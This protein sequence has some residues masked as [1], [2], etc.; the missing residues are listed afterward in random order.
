M[1]DLRAILL[2]PVLALADPAP[3]A[4]PPPPPGV[5]PDLVLPRGADDER[6]RIPLDDALRELASGLPV[7][8]AARERPGVA[9]GAA[10]AALRHYLAA[11][12]DLLEERFLV[13]ATHLR[14]ARQLD[15]GSTEI[16]RELAHAY[17]GLRDASRERAAYAELFR[18]D[19]GDPEAQFSMGLVALNQRDF[20]SAARLFARVRLDGTDTSF[21]PAAPLIIDHALHLTL[22]LLGYD[23]ASI[24]AG[25]RATEDPQFVSMT[26]YR[27]RVAGIM[28]RRP[29]IWREIGEAHLR[30]VERDQALDA[31]R[32]SAEL[33]DTPRLAARRAFALLGLGRGDEAQRELVAR[34]DVA[35]G[36]MGDDLVALSR[37]LFEPAGGASV[38]VRDAIA[39]LLERRPDDGMLLRV[40]YWALRSPGV[41][42]RLR[43]RVRREPR[44]VATAGLLMAIL[45]DDEAVDLAVALTEMEPDLAADY[46]S[47]LLAAAPRPLPRLAG[48]DANRPAPES[49]V[50]VEIAVRILL[51]RTGLG[52]AWRWCGYGRERWPVDAS[53]HRLEIEVAAALDEPELLFA[54]LDAARHLDDAPTWTV[55]ASALTAIEEY[56]R[57]IEAAQRAR[58]SAIDDR[59]RLA[60]GDALV[61][62]H[63]ARAN[64]MSLDET[65][66]E[67]VRT[68]VQL[69]ESLEATDPADKQR[70]L[71][72][73]AFLHG[74]SGLRPSAARFNRTVA[75]ACRLR[76]ESTLCWQLQAQEA[77][78]F[79]QYELALTRALSLVER[80]A[81]DMKSLGQVLQALEQMQ[82]V[83]DAE[84]WLLSRLERT[85]GLPEPLDRLVRILVALD[86]GGEALTLL[87]Q[88]REANPDD[89]A[90]TRLLEMVLQMSGE[91]EAAL[92]LGQ[93]RL[94]GRPAGTRRALQRALLLMRAGR[95]D[96]ATER[97]EWLI[98][99]DRHVP[100]RHLLGAIA[101]CAQLPPDNGRREELTAE[102]VERAVEQYADLPM[103]VYALGLQALAESGTEAR[104]RRLAELG[105]RHS[106][107]ADEGSIERLLAWRELAQGLVNGGHA[108]P[109][110]VALRTRLAE[111][112][113]IGGEAP[114]DPEA[115][116]LVVSM[117]VAVDSLSPDGAESSL[118]M[119]VDLSSKGALPALPGG[120]DTPTLAKVLSGAGD[121]YSVVGNKA[122]S[123][124]LMRESVRLDPTHAMTLNN[125][126]YMLLETGHADDGVQAWIE[127]A[128]AAMPTAASVIDTLAWLRYK[129]GRIEDDADGDGAI[130]LLHRA[131]ELEDQDVPEMLDH[132]GDALWR[133]GRTDE[134]VHAWRRAVAALE[135]PSRRE[136]YVRN[137]R[138]LQNL[139]W[140]LLVADPQELYDREHRPRL[141]HMR[142]KL[143]DAGRGAR[144]PIEPTFVESLP[145]S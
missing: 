59:E 57:A 63:A 140:G 12:D 7:M 141:E 84:R 50:H 52:A 77:L 74:S 93:A 55:R 13:A 54:A 51:R 23:R 82:R 48:G 11:R 26:R 17:A 21:D 4:D 106:R 62:A 92:T 97:I 28:G 96:E 32:R 45:E 33:M 67:A 122:G 126:G 65:R 95:S 29:D 70:L 78:S 115:L 71:E 105:A 9:P 56:E 76:P 90:A 114:L 81:T 131:L 120:D 37:Y 139:V 121:F 49:V 46:V 111:S 138:D 68:T 58:L 125:L 85:G 24:G 144:P 47:H 112:L 108:R 75:E 83:D 34:L 80:D 79:G 103:N 134:A 25:V 53:M 94:D 66:E 31:F 136:N 100:R 135:V 107:G 113:R 99:H 20:T 137:Y 69:A 127:T 101:L 143:D 73:F 38:A 89:P 39:D 27:R 102:L 132:L 30:L 18:L 119:L 87:E 43:D 3:A 142:R 118:A 36:A 15:P 44:D 10:D 104:F 109:A 60:A 2:V 129:Q 88:R 130:T 116:A 16:L 124:Y 5:D 41:G 8:P 61:R 91:T 22:A 145:G 19:P 72:L 86:R 6:A 128:A 42:E 35:P 133:A 98:E 117:I 40:A 110:A 64:R 1:P 123:Q 14:Q